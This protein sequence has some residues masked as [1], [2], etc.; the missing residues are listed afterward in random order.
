[1]MKQAMGWNFCSDELGAEIMA[2]IVDLVKRKRVKPV[3][4]EVVGFED[5]PAAITRMRD[6]QTTGR[7]IVTVD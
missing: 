4:G 7:V 2:A 6:R 3:I 5:L 1:M